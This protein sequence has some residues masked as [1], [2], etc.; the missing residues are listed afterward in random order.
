[1]QF[2]NF[3]TRELARKYTFC[4]NVLMLLS[5]CAISG[6]ASAQS[7]P[8]SDA[9]EFVAIL[10]GFSTMWDVFLRHSRSMNAHCRFT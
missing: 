10:K 4:I 2:I 3:K 1:M 7:Q 9:E 6:T 8:L 5:L